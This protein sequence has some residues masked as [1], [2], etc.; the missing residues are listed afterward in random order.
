MPATESCILPSMRNWDEMINARA[1]ATG[2]I[3]IVVLRMSK[4]CLISVKGVDTGIR[5]KYNTDGSSLT[6]RIACVIARFRPGRN[7][8]G[9]K[10]YVK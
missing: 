6:S 2:S 9:G 3:R 4:V 10:H 5:A 1:E 8:K 7:T